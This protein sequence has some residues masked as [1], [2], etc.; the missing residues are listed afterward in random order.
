MRCY[1]LS[2]VSQLSSVFVLLCSPALHIWTA[3]I[4]IDLRNH[5]VLLTIKFV[6]P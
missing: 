2:L 4:R 5:V 3:G 6:V 1:G